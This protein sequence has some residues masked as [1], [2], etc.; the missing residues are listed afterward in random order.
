VKNKQNTV[1]QVCGGKFGFLKK[2]VAKFIMS[3]KDPEKIQTPD[4]IMGSA[5][6]VSR[7]ALDKVGYMDERFFMYFEDVDWARR[8]WH[9]GYIVV[10]YP[11][12]SLYHYHQRES[13]SS[14]GVLDIFFNKKTRWH[15]SSALKFFWKYRDLSKPQ[16][17]ILHE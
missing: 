11:F 2:A 16:P 3:D 1:H 12:S 10:Y 14:L 8:F 13:K 9:N 4:W 6:M 15:I 7:K 17:I 5:M